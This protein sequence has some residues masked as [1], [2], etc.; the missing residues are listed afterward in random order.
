M[1]SAKGT[2][3]SIASTFTP[4]RVREPH[5]G[6]RTPWG[7]ADSV[8]RVGVG[9]H[10]VSTPGHG[11]FKLSAAQNKR[12]D[13]AW[14]NAGGWYE[15][16]CEYA[17]V[18]LTFGVDAGFSPDQVSDCRA[19]CKNVFPDAYETVYGV[20]VTPDESYVVR[21]RLSATST[22]GAFDT[23]YAAFC[24]DTDMWC[25]FH[26]RAV[27]DKPAGFAFASFADQSQAEEDATARQKAASR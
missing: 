9:V 25:V 15:E 27:G 23:Y 2:Y 4:R 19:T 1:F 14:R 20:K 16:D 22:T 21:E 13:P 24:N 8:R 11:G 26:T 10:E 18:G 3:P 5:V 12:V 7:K 17:I 6:M